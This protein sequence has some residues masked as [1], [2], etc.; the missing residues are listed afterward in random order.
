MV[1]VPIKQKA[2]TLQEN[3]YTIQ[4]VAANQN[5]HVQMATELSMPVTT[6]NGIME[7]KGDMFMS[8]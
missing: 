6:L 3:L 8:Q 1:A 7:K 5:T 2:M 4:R